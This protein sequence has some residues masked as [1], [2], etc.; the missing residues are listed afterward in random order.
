MT[1]SAGAE[2]S[3]VMP[4][5]VLVIGG[6]VIGLC[7]AYYALQKGHRVTVL[8][9]HAPDHEGCSL[10]NAGMVVPSHFVPLAAP[11]MPA[12][13]LRMLLRPDGPFSIHPRLNPALAEW[14]WKFVRASTAAH[15]TRAAPALRDLSLASRREFETLAREWGNTFGLVQKGLLM[16]CRS[17]HALEEEAR[18]VP[19]ARALGLPAERL[20]P[21]EVACLDPGIRMDIAGAVYFPLDC[22]LSPQQ[23]MAGLAR[24]V[25]ARGGTVCWGT[26][27]TGWRTQGGAVDAVQTD[28][29]D[30]QAD[31]YVLAGGSWSSDLAGKLGLRLPMQAGKGYSVT[32][33]QPKRLPAL[34]SILTEARVA[35]TP[36]GQTLRL[37]GMM[38]IGGQDQSPNQRRVQGI[39]D[40]VPRYFPELSPDDLRGLPVWSGLRPCSPDGLPYLGRFSRYAN[41]SAA[42]G[43]C[44]MGVSLAPITGK[45]LA[46]VLSDQPPTVSLS[47]F[48]PDRYMS[49]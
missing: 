24:E 20:T 27:V 28:Q 1:P 32:L 8:E 3:R 40:A 36:M 6:G 16:L 42:T 14:A 7:V 34:C 5:S 43:H 10:G 17:E 11:G 44:M 49:C 26:T 47:P 12:L 2:S 29:G 30:R 35:V 38:E 22:H 45:V 31:E 23:L 33:P 15:V 19:Q 4:K 37:G 41:L 25:Q 21:E 18:L 9:R 39:L 46:E 48:R 13:G